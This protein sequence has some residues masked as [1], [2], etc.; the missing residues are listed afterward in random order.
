MEGFLPFLEVYGL[1]L[2][3]SICSVQVILHIVFYF[4]VFVGE[5]EQHVL[6]STIL[7]L[8][9]SLFFNCFLCCEKAFKLN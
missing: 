8:F 3:F 9:P 2:V 4:D 5:G 1:L 7:I 6:S